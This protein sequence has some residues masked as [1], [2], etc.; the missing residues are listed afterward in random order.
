M[1]HPPSA[2]PGPSRTSSVRASGAAAVT[3]AMALL[4]VLMYGF[5]LLAA[6]RLGPDDFGAVSAFLG[7]TLITNVGALA[8][9]TTAARRIAVASPA[10]RASVAHDVAVSGWQLTVV[11]TA[12]AVAAS[13]ALAHLLHTDLMA[14]LFT[15]LTVGPLTMVGAYFGLLQ[16][17]DRWWPLS[18][19]LLSNG[20]GRVVFGLA[21]IV[22]SPT[23]AGAMAG[24][25]L[26][27]CVPLLVAWWF[28]RDVPHS[29]RG[30]NRPVLREVWH[31]GH[32]LLAYFALT[33][34]DVLLARNQF[35]H[36]TA[37][38][39]A[40]GSL[41]TK[42]CFLLPQI[43][44]I[45]LFPAMAR[46]SS[47]GTAWLKPVAAIGALGLLGVAATALL[48]DLALIFVGGDKYADMASYAW[49][50]ALEGT[51]FAVLQMVVYRQIAQQAR[52]ARWMW[53]GSAIVVAGAVLLADGNRSLV[54]LVTV[55]VVLL[56][57]P[58]WLARPQ[59]SP[60]GGS[61]PSG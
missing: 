13:P 43:V 46:D 45:V 42:A 5:N 18:W 44:L 37:G 29:S 61:T 28:C 19:S 48:D 36:H 15:A 35:D 27:A 52:V 24:V 49:L 1:S 51:A 47:R 60:A 22:I 31:N 53:A 55:V 11:L 50:F 38:L 23:P 8:L 2:S 9:Q 17:A 33:N 57:V 54:L 26:G 20:V 34:L 12:L 59:R 6:H 25:A 41:I 39:Y 32:T 16:G 58:V 14:A 4:S 3:G 56:A 10:D 30:T 21:G 40:A 7:I